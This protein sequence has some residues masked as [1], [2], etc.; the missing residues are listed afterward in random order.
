MT[1]VRRACGGELCIEATLAVAE[2]VGVDA[3]PDVDVPNACAF[4]DDN[5]GPVNARHQ[6]EPRSPGF[7]P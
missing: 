1:Y 5:C 7:S 4:G 6:R 2:L 3:I